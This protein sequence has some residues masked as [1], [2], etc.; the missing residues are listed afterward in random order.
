MGDVERPPRAGESARLPGSYQP[1][2]RFD[3]SV[4]DPGDELRGEMFICG[5]GHVGHMKLG[6]YP[7][8]GFVDETDSRISYGIR[9]DQGAVVF[10]GEHAIVG[11]AGL[12]LAL[13]NGLVFDVTSQPLPMVSTEALVG[14]APVAFRLKTPRTVRP[15]THV[16][17]FVLTYFNGERWATATQSV[18]FTVRNVLQRH[19]VLVTA[20]GSAAA[21][22][23]VAGA[24]AEVVRFFMPRFP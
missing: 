7:S 8:Q 21:L 22:A 17:F 14:Q 20:L 19:E 9:D 2:V 24:A 16:L 18:S 11:P 3:A 12:T 6:F 5:Y 4:I 13:P 15:G 10:G 1:A 23:A